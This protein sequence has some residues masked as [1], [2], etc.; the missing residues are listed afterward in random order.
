MSG[1]WQV[2]DKCQISFDSLVIVIS[3]RPGPSQGMGISGCRGCCNNPRPLLPSR[4]LGPCPSPAEAVDVYGPEAWFPAPWP[5]PG[6]GD[7]KL[8]RGSGGPQRPRPGSE[9]WARSS[10]GASSRWRCESRRCGRPSASCGE[11]SRGGRRGWT[12]C[13]TCR[14]RGWRCSCAT[15]GTPKTARSTSLL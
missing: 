9:P 2:L 7:R 8:P 11:R 4:S 1:I 3:A 10:R 13:W 6:C 5:I 12:S 15:R 14:Q